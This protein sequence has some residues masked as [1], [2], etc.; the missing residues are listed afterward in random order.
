LPVA[1]DAELREIE[2]QIRL[3]IRDAVNRGS[4]KPF[5]WGGLSGY[6]Q[7]ESIAEALRGLPQGPAAAYLNR[8]AI[9]VERAVQKN[10]WLAQDLAQAHHWLMRIAQCLRYPPSDFP[11][12]EGAP[13][14][15]LSS[16]WVRAEMEALLEQFH[17]DLKRQ[18]AQ[19]ALDHAWR[20]LWRT[21]G[22]DLLPCYDI[23]GLPPDNLKM[24]ALFGQLRRHQ[25][26]ISGHKSTRPLRDFGQ[27]QVLFD[28]QSEEELQKQLQRTTQEDYQENRRRLAQAEEPR[29][30]L[31][32]LHRDPVATARR[33]VERHAVRRAAL[34]QYPATPP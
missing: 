18:P 5:H 22:A 8:L 1:R 6:Q 13:N 26:R 12:S 28:A 9:Q 11:A 29:Q 27:Y 25:R 24:E 23:R 17:P 34:A 4:R 15:V 32:R 2:G 31:H 21:W 30:Q 19:R 3:A 10:R 20:R 33:L 14:S 16:R 7:L